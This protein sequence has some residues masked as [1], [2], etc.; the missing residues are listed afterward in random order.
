MTNL[1][2]QAMPKIM[3]HSFQIRNAQSHE[4][5]ETGKLMVSV[6]SQLNGFPKPADQPDYYKMLANIGELTKKP[7]TELIV[8]ISP[9]GKICGG[10]VYFSDMQY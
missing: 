2:Y 1:G 4:F 3:P 8:A 5:E 9:G 6:Y 7:A 10:V